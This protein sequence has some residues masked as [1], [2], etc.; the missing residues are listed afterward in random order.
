MNLYSFPIPIASSQDVGAK[1]KRP[2]RSLRI[3]KH[4]MVTYSKH[5]NLG[6]TI[7]VIR[8]FCWLAG[9]HLI[10]VMLLIRIP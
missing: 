7:I 3:W 4:E 10:R 5:L 9:L 8:I 1:A 2:N 6:L